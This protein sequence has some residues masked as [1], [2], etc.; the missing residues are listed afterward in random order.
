MVW[1]RPNAAQ[2]LS[3]AYME[4]IDGEA[5]GLAKTTSAYLADAGLS[6]IACA[7]LAVLLWALARRRRPS[8]EPLPS[9][10]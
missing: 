2:M 7:A 6:L 5:Y 8:A 1:G 10:A 3:L 9:V 4:T